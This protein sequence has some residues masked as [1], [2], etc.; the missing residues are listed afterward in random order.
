MLSGKVPTAPP[1]LKFPVV[2]KPPE[3]EAVEED[4]HG[5]LQNI[6]GFSFYVDNW[7]WWNI[8]SQLPARWAIILGMCCK[9]LN[10]ICRDEA[11]W[12]EN[13]KEL[14]APDWE[15]PMAAGFAL[16]GKKWKL[17]PTGKCRSRCVRDVMLLKAGHGFFCLLCEKTQS[18]KGSDRWQ[19]VWEEARFVPLHPRSS[20]GPASSGYCSKRSECAV[21]CKECMASQ[22]ECFYCKS[23]SP[24]T[25]LIFRELVFNH[26][27]CLTPGCGQAHITLNG[28]P[29]NT[30]RSSGWF[31]F[32]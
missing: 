6:N 11:L 4:D 10:K 22:L 7:T 30:T 18:L 13:L 15:D 31:T 19:K 20:S 14:R 3:K 32:H 23:K 5:V 27:A 24:M 12:V 16:E 29:F 2:A 9:A 17:T 21:V 8:A 26:R 25:P 1:L 28:K